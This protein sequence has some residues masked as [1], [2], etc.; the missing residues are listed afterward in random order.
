[1]RT[2]RGTG[3]TC[4]PVSFDSSIHNH[5]PLWATSTLLAAKSAWPPGT[6]SYNTS[7]WPETRYVA[8]AGRSQPGRHDSR[9]PRSWTSDP[10]RPPVP[11]GARRGEPV[12]ST[13]ERRRTPGGSAEVRGRPIAD[14]CPCADASA[15]SPARRHPS[16]RLRNCGCRPVRDDDPGRS[17]RRV[18]KI[19]STTGLQV[20]LVTR[21]GCPG[22]GESV[23]FR[24]T[25]RVTT[26]RRSPAGSSPLPTWFTTTFAPELPNASA[27][28]VTRLRPLIPPSSS[29]TSRDMEI[30]VH[31]H[32]ARGRPDGASA[33]RS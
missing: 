13:A 17:W 18:I 14:E 4:T 2:R 8:S 23:A 20:R 19:E 15:P 31:S 30:P 7:D 5:H 1:M 6:S 11:P 3:R 33:L 16:P 12:A 27:S 9:D 22:R 25:S 32:V 10:A 21:R 26:G 28:A 24:S 29:A